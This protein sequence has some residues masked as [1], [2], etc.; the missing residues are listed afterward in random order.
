MDWE[1]GHVWN[2]ALGGYL[3]YWLCQW[4]PYVVITLY[5]QTES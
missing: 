3:C 1:S 4:L 5:N 2:G